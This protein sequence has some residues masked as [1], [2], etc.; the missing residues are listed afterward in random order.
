MAIQFLNALNVQG[1][2]DLN[3]NQLVQV[4][5]E[6]LGT[7]PAATAGRMYYNSGD[8]SLRYY[9]G[10]GA[11]WISL[12]GTGDVDSIAVATGAAS[13][14]NLLS[15]NS[16]TGAVT[17][18]SHA[19][20]GTSNIGYVPTG[21]TSATFL[22][23]DGTWVTPTDSTPV[24]SVD[25]TT[26]GTSTGTPIVVNPTTGTVLVKSMAYAGTTN[27]GHVPAG[28][29]ASTFLRGDGTWVTPSGSYTDWNLAGDTGTPQ[30]ITDGNTATFAGGTGIAT[31][32]G[33]TDTLTITNTGVTSAVA[34]TGI[35]VSGATG[36]VTFTNTG[37]TSIVAGTGIS[38]S[39]AT[40]AVTITNTQTETDTTYTL[41]TTNGNNPDL[42]LT[43]GGSGSGTD[44][45]NLNGTGTT[46][47]VTGSGNDTITFDLVDDVTIAGELTVSGTGQSSFGGQVTVPTT[48]SASTDAA[49][50]AY[51][52]T[53]TTG[54]LVFQGGYDASGNPN[55]SAE[56]GWTYVVTVAGSGTG[57]SFWSVP[58]EIGDL[59][60]ANQDDPVDEDDWT[61]VN[62]NVTLASNT[63]VGVASFSSSNFTVSGAG[64]VSISNVDLGTETTGNY[65]AT[66]AADTTALYKGIRVSGATGEGQAAVV[67]I[68]V[69]GLTNLG[70]APADED[71]LIIL[72]EGSNE[73]KSVTVA[74]LRAA[75]VA[76]TSF[77]DLYPQGGAAASWTVTHN[78]ST[79]NVIVQCYRT[80]DDVTVFTDVVR[81]SGS[82]VTITCGASQ[83]EDTIQVMV[84]KA[85]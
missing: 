8:G 66:V 28:G 2:V 80:S 15:V 27:V 40:G 34:S 70:A 59:I 16:S 35:S 39:G 12:D 79:K 38:I 82:V 21:G 25:E 77:T 69:S 84:I 60:I 43:A 13:S 75:T 23:G 78:L 71:E 19:Y 53:A 73:N 48:P 62:K 58:L 68:N 36:A 76:V 11:S 7:N 18:S 50:K 10:V 33:S 1:N 44:I 41:P 52:D 55:S 24:D 5:I 22:R 45:V 32:A 14:G 26:P 4:R 65:T 57:G 49:S 9:D 51:V 17:I 30:D 81:T 74:N 6:N 64:A 31:A 85:G 29:G 46:V 42:V 63:V 83:A 3:A 20:A 56:Q 72:D 61:E 37:V 54:A 47:K 67:G